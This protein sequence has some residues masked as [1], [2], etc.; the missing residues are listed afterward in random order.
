MPETVCVGM[1]GEFPQHPGLM[2][3]GEMD[4]AGIGEGFNCFGI[5]IHAGLR[6]IAVDGVMKVP[7]LGNHEDVIP[8]DEI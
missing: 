5:G 8:M 4:D 1:M 2:V 6:R 3:T 7:I